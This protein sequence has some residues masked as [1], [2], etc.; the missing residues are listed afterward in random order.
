MALFDIAD[1]ILVLEAVALAEQNMGVYAE[2]L[3]EMKIG[4]AIPS[5]KQLEDL[6]KLCRNNETPLRNLIAEL[7]RSGSKLASSVEWGDL[8]EIAGSEEAADDWLTGEQWPYKSYSH[9]KL[10]R[11][12][13]LSKETY[14]DRSSRIAPTMSSAGSSLNLTSTIQPL[15]MTDTFLEKRPT[16]TLDNSVFVATGGSL[17]TS[18]TIPVAKDVTTTS[19]RHA[20]LV[21]QINSTIAALAEASS[22][23]DQTRKQISLGTQPHAPRLQ[24]ADVAMPYERLEYRSSLDEKRGVVDLSYEARHDLYEVE[25][26]V[27]RNH[28]TETRPST[29]NALCVECGHTWKEPSTHTLP[30]AFLCELCSEGTLPTSTRHNYL[31]LWD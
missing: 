19:N 5:R 4:A 22:R 10:L 13:S 21:A 30:C 2:L 15:P 14:A 11:H 23:A 16:D 31:N 24:V 1:P 7:E 12:S 3:G 26:L 9:E 25:R 28:G 27:R 18:T 20:D 6:C 8:V 29:R 17:A